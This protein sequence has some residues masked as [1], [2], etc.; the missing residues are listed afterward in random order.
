MNAATTANPDY[1]AFL[2]GKVVLA[3]KSGFAVSPGELNPGNFP[4]QNDVIT[5]A[6]G[7]GRRGYGVELSTKYFGF[8]IRYYKEIEA[9]IT[10]P[11]LFDYLKT[12]EARP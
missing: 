5:W 3:S 1:S 7:L 4:F 10:T 11:T 9:E 12:Q 8:G 2:E 6:A